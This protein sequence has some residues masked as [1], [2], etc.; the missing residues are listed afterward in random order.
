MEQLRARRTRTTQKQEPRRGMTQKSSAF[1]WIPTF[2]PVSTYWGI[3]NWIELFPILCFTQNLI[4]RTFHFAF[5]NVITFWLRSMYW[6]WIY[7]S[8]F[9]LLT[10][11]I[12]T[13]Q[14]YCFKECSRSPQA[15]TL[16][17]IR[18][19]V[20]RIRRVRYL[21]IITRANRPGEIQ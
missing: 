2:T 1:S 6:A 21:P 19:V 4:D 15:I 20:V 13:Q 12:Y 3:E 5:V 10:T 16:I 17:T 18:R 7:K 11:L 14:N 8:K 9:R